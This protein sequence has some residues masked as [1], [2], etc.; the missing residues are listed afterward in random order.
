MSQE[1]RTSRESL[2]DLLNRHGI[3]DRRV[4]RR[5][6]KDGQAVLDGVPVGGDAVP[7]EGASLT[8][9]GKR[10]TIVASREPGRLTPV[11]E[12]VDPPA[13]IDAKIRVHC[14]YHK[15]LTIY[16]KRVSKKTAFWD[17]PISGSYRHFFHRADEFYWDCGRQRISSL[18]GNRLDLDRFSDLKAVHIVRDPRDLIVSGY[19][20][21][22]RAAEP[23]CRDR[24]P[25]EAD[26]AIVNG[27][28]P[29]S[30]PAGTSLS[31]YLNG[32]SQEEGLAAEIAFRR[33]HLE[34]MEAWPV[35][36][37]RVMTV[38]YEDILGNEADV[39]GKIYDFYGLAPPTR[40]AARF[41]AGHYSAAGRRRKASHIRN[42]Q[43]GQWKQH[44]T[45]ALAD[46]FQERY[47]RL[48]EKYGY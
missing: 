11:P 10:Y 6:F 45:P 48:L 36:D 25:V 24:D 12:A 22:L 23:W 4:H 21:H 31:D 29:D 40:W 18:S 47:G 15:C 42:A 2:H 41:F 14:G 44:F 33:R 8:L 35:D 3:G 39:F 17:N 27:C 13:R 37:P 28:V 34:S 9:R 43:F 38:R 5:W 1:T 30:L 32:V 16:F 46:A 26:W 7:R 20:Y 19:F